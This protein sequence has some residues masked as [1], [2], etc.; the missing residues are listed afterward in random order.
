LTCFAAAHGDA[1]E[2]IEHAEEIPE[3]RSF[4]NRGGIVRASAWCDLIATAPLATPWSLR[5]FLSAFE[6]LHGTLGLGGT[7][8][9]YSAGLALFANL[10]GSI[11]AVWSLARLCALEA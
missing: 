10:L 11:V 3:Q 8:P 5:W 4:I 1:L 6:H 9:A 7:V 2:R